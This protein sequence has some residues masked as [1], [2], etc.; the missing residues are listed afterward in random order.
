MRSLRPLTFCLLALLPLAG[1]SQAP[2][3]PDADALILHLKNA[4]FG[5][6]ADRLWPAGQAYA[7]AVLAADADLRDALADLLAVRQGQHLWS[8]DDQ[9]WHDAKALQTQLDA[10]EPIIGE[11]TRAARQKLVA[12]LEAAVTAIPTGLVEGPTQREKFLAAIWSALALRREDPRVLEA[13]L[14]ALAARHK[15]LYTRALG[16]ARQAAATQPAAVPVSPDDVVR[17]LRDLKQTLL[18]LW[19]N[20]AAHAAV[21]I[22]S[23]EQ[24]KRDLAKERDE[25]QKDLQR[26]NTQ[27][28][29]QQRLAW[30]AALLEHQDHRIAY[31]QKRKAAADALLG[32]N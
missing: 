21:M 26:R 19:T 12:A 1:C 22:A 10:L 18:D 23:A 8:G 13:E 7:D 6:P 32:E 11:K 25:L 5:A 30:I 31:Y 16:V 27:P 9:R 4:R 3:E 14:T 28:E 2:T 15:L 29:D 24:L 20:D 17:D